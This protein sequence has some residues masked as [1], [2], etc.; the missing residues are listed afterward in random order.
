MKLVIII[1]FLLPQL[2]FGQKSRA[3]S[4]DSGK[5]VEDS[6]MYA[7]LKQRM[8]K[9][10]LGREIYGAVFRDVYNTNAQ[11]K[12][13]SQLE[14]NPFE[15]YEGKTIG[16]ITIKKLEIFGPS[17]NDTIRKGN[18]FEHFA[19]KTFH[20]ST[21]DQVIRKSFLLF[22]EGDVL[23]AKTLKDNERLFRSNAI[24]HDARIFVIERKEID[25]IVDILVVVQDVWSI[26]FDVSA[27]GF[28]DFALGLED[29]NFHGNG[30]SLLG[31]V[32]WRADDPFQRLG[33]RGIY[34]VPYIGKTFITGQIN[35][36]V[37]RDLSQFS[38]KVNRPFLTTDIRNAGSL[39][40]GYFKN[41][42]YKRLIIN[43]ID[44]LL[45]YQVGY[46]YSDIWYGRSFKIDALKPNKQV[47]LAVRRSS[48]EYNKR[49]E[50]RLDTNRIY[51]NRTTWLGSIGFSNR[52]YQRD[53]L[54][55]GFGRTEDVPVGNLF[56]LTFGTENTEFGNRN[57]AGFQFAKG[58]YLPKNEGYFYFLANAGSYLKQKK[59]QQGVIGLQGFY[60]SKLMKLG[61]SHGRQFVNLGFTY[62][63][64][65]DAVDYL[66]ISGK[67]GILGVNSD[68]LR[69]DKR[70]TLGF[71]SVLFSRKS[72]VGF[73]IAYFGFANFG[74]VSLKDNLLTNSKLYQ[75]YG[76]GL[77]FR[78]ENLTFNTFQIRLGYY[79]NI[80]DISSPWRFAFDGSQPLRLRD[81]DISAPS[82]IPLR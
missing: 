55:Y 68:G 8:N 76:L 64:N 13:I 57:Y 45:I 43:R 73:R 51:W 7:R 6:V 63:I 66:N 31:K 38:V 42:E 37:E 75:G 12:E 54:V 33:L 56:S 17:V 10:R 59:I 20:Y 44:S 5:S 32:T 49:P 47:I 78:N 82:I 24:I 62:G 70:L 69:G 58:T 52:N 2:I 39:E 27:S 16:K 9:S 26:N 30:H 3:D 77:R 28:N 67:E 74:L 19:S 36:I 35:A 34:T 4:L 23:N 61:Q 81:F 79:P 15:Q 29:R 11:N 72:F 22:K 60:F 46:F 41:R 18:R 80:P 53:I 25:W 40:L 21:R 48:Y 71:E 50:V 14:V 1:L 65:R